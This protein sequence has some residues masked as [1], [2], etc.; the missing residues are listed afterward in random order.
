LNGG[1]C[2]TVGSLDMDV[3]SIKIYSEYSVV[4]FCMLQL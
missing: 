4:A 2:Y 3:D 1:P